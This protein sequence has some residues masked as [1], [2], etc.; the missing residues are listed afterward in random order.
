MHHKGYSE[1]LNLAKSRL[2]EK[3]PSEICANTGVN[4]NGS[5]Y[6]LPWFG[7]PTGIDDGTIEETILRYHYAL[8]N[9]PKKMRGRYINY[10]QIP[11]AAI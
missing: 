5:D 9:G 7:I 3:S 8:A 11:G 4:F 6:E 1:A 2:A 10:K